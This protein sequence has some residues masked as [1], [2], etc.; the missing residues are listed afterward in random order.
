M[1]DSLDL[2]ATVW[3]ITP[4]R[5]ALDSNSLSDVLSV[6]RTA[7]EADGARAAS[8][9]TLV[10]LRSGE[11]H[12]AE[13]FLAYSAAPGRISARDEEHPSHTPVEHLAGFAVVT[14]TGGATLELVVHP[15]FRQQ[16]L[17][18]ALVEA[19][20]A[21]VAHDGLVDT[22]SIHAWA[23]GNLQAAAQLAASSGFTPVRHLVK[24]ARPADASLPAARALPVGLRLRSFRPGQDDEAWV[25]LN[26]RVFADHP[27]QGSLTVKDLRER[28]TES[29]F[30]AED[31]LLVVDDADRMLGFNWLKRTPEEAE[32]YAIGISPDAQGLG[33]GS[34]LTHAG[35]TRLQS[36]GPREV[37][38]YTE[39]DNVKALSL[40]TGLDFEQTEQD[41]MYAIDER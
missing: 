6:L 27:E 37:T 34:V 40:Y 21:T 32:I 39:G 29:W 35:I 41:V 36:E 13:T 22:A 3:T 25:E 8:D 5:G 2:E 38:L 20:V 30:D 18:R 23:H 16:G 12:Q 9:Q 14:E 4:V 26:A 28:M 33:L 24:M 17:G 11:E 1:D 31:F 15:D 10:L 7:E 19:A